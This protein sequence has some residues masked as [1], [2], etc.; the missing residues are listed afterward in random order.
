M[1]SPAIGLDLRPETSGTRRGLGGPL[2]GTGISYYYTYMNVRRGLFRLWIIFACMFV[3]GI[4]VVS[5]YAIS[6]EFEKA[7]EMKSQRENI[8]QS[9]VLRVPCFVP[10]H[11]AFDWSEKADGFCGYDIRKFRTQHPLYRDLNDEQLLGRL[12]E[13]AR[14]NVKSPFH[15]WRRVTEAAAI[16][17]GIPGAMLIL[18]LAWCWA[19]SGFRPALVQ[20]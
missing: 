5:R 15:P 8:I 9:G 13:Q 1:A 11:T 7:G 6:R 4:L 14:I 12:C 3:I 18:G 19:Y 10:G 17:V 2:D 16:A 20:V